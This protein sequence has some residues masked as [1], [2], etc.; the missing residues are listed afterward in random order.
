MQEYSRDG[1]TAIGL[2]IDKEKHMKLLAFCQRAA[3]SG[4]GFDPYA[5]ARSCLPFVFMPDST[6]KTFCS[7]YVTDALQFAGVEE[8]MHL[9]SLL[10]S[11][12]F[13]L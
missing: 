6:T 12:F 5:M 3:A 1:Y 11:V 4:I 10:L 8:L 9:V 7:K 13:L 2:R